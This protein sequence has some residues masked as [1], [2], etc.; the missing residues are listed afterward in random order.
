VTVKATGGVAVNVTVDPTNAAFTGKATAEA[1][2]LTVD[3]TQVTIVGGDAAG[4]FYG[5]QTLAGLIPADTTAGVK[6]PQIQVTYDAPR[7]SYRGLQLELARNFLGLNEVLKVIEQMAAYK[8]NSLHL[9]L[10]DDEGWRLEIPS[11]PELTALGSNRCFDLTEKTCLMSQLGSGPTTTSSG[12]GFLKQADFVAI[13]KAAKARYIDVIPEFDMP[14]HAR[15]AVKSMQTRTDTTY[16]LSDPQDMSTYET[17]QYYSDNAINACL[18]STYAF[19][20]KVMDDVNAMYT[21]AGATLHT[22]HIGADEVAAGAWTK[23]PACQALFADGG[24]PSAAYL[25]GYF[26]EKVNALAKARGFAIRGWSDGL[27]KAVASPDG[28]AP[29]SDWLDPTADLGGNTVSANWWGTLFWWDNR[30]YQLADRG[31]KVILTSPD[32]LYLD[33]PQEADP[34]ERGYYWATRYTSER[35]LFSYIPG[36]LPEN[37]KLT[38]DRMGNDYTAVFQPSA[39]NPTPVTVSSPQ[40]IIGMEAAQWGET[41]RT[42]D[43]FEYQVFPRLLA[44]A[45]RAWHRAGWE[46]AD[47]SGTTWDVA[48]DMTALG[49]DWQR[50]ANVLGHKELPKLDK[51]S[52]HYRVDVPGGQITA[53][54]A[55]QAISAFPGMTIEY[56]SGSGNPDASGTPDGGNWVTYNSAS[57]PMLSSTQI[58]AKSSDGRAGRAISVP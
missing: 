41:M 18:D 14:G 7:Y 58:R 13:L 45:E 54:G 6:V 16:A 38:K 1:Y 11:L 42:T 23:S 25:Q 27:R 51:Q 47:I 20:G 49:T 33:H 30:A 50:F 56:Q 52:I 4:A 48:I 43:E 46:P 15:A 22:W 24:V 53:A 21:Q 10:S 28:G 3:G 44:M 8:L 26:I 55:L 19:V 32:F 2:T 35:K 34:M 39:A 31:Y 36:N 37:S 12:T 9:H 29:G 57:P 17:V 40:N 5:L